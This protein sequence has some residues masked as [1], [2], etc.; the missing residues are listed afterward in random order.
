M[1]IRWYNQTTNQT[2]AL[3][4]HYKKFIKMFKPRWSIKFKWFRNQSRLQFQ[5][6]YQ[7]ISVLSRWLFVI[8][9]WSILNRNDMI[10]WFIKDA[11]K[12]RISV[13]YLYTRPVHQ[14]SIRTKLFSYISK[15]EL[16]R[17]MNSCRIKPSDH[18]EN[19]SY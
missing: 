8:N 1:N 10:K 15:E 7:W 13:S 5:Y 19:D 11:T 4:S 17:S 2:E 14:T 12:F 9:F 3:K 18:T 16:I 6:Q